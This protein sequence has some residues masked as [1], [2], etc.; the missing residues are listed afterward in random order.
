MELPA[1]IRDGLDRARQLHDRAAS[2]YTKC[3]EFNKLMGE[4]LDKLEDAGQAKLADQ[5]MTLLIDCNPKE[6]S[7][8]EH[9]ERI[10]KKVGKM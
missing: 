2:D 3:L 10:G 9:A 7:K 6:G 8:C 4:L 5:V 1:D